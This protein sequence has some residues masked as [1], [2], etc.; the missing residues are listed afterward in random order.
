VFVKVQVLSR[1]D[2]VDPAIDLAG[3]M[4]G[5]LGSLLSQ[6]VGAV[7]GVFPEGPDVFDQVVEAAELGAQVAEDSF[8][9]RLHLFSSPPDFTQLAGGRIPAES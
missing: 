6:V 5:D 8:D 3:F 9:L 2:R 1:P 4:A 7:L